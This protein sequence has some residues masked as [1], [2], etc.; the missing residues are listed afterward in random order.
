MTKEEGVALAESF[1]RNSR[2]DNEPE[3]S[4]DYDGIQVNGEILV[5]PY[6]SV[7]YLETR[8]ELVRLLDCWPILV[9]LA[10]G[11]VRFGTLEDRPL[12]KSGGV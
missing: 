6:N 4:L 3:M 10:T 11:G 1:L 8:E 9:N 7:E 2:R 5:V 12:W